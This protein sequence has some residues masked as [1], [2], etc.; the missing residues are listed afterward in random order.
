MHCSTYISSCVYFEYN[1][2]RPVREH[3][4]P[5]IIWISYLK[6]H[7]LKR[8]LNWLSRTTVYVPGLH[9]IWACAFSKVLWC[10]QILGVYFANYSWNAPIY[11][12]KHLMTRNVHG[13]GVAVH[14]H[15]PDYLISA[16][17]VLRFVPPICPL[18]RSVNF[19]FI[20]ISFLLLFRIPF[21]FLEL[22][23]CSSSFCFSS[24]SRN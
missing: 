14:A 24:C 17:W 12:P 4:A 21:F 2:I 13:E 22:G 6:C 23:S 11:I 16:S 20:V 10:Y 1:F 3:K 18:C 19:E 9:E 8:Y 15:F 7:K 5:N